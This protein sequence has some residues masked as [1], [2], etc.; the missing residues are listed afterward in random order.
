MF[1]R[2]APLLKLIA[3][4]SLILF[5][6]DAAVFRSGVYASWM[7]PDSTGGSVVGDIAAIRHYTDST[8][9]NVLVLGN[10]QIGEGFSWP[11]A[12]AAIG[13][14]DL[15]FVNGSVAGTTPRLWSYLLREIDPDCS[16]YAAIVMMIDYDL[17]R[18][19]S[20]FADYPLD[21]SYATPL[22]RIGD[23]DDYPS[24]FG[25]PDLRARA[26]RAILLPLQAAHE[27]ILNFI[28]HPLERWEK[29]VKGRPGWIAA[30]AVY[31]GHREALPTLPID[32]DTGMPSAW[33]PDAATLKPKLESYFRD[34]RKYASAEAMSANIDYQRRWV[35]RI[36]QC[37][38]AH[39]VPVIAFNVPRGPWH[40]ALTAAP[41]PNAALL[42]LHKAGTITLLPGDAF[43]QFEQPQFF[44]DTLHM[45]HTGREA[46]SALLAQKVAPLVH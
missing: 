12:D 46:F 16:R 45:N 9:R 39:D 3:A 30:T 2:I 10:S 38:R 18:W 6:I 17:S 1:K 41:Q 28:V 19:R 26:R 27:D 42:D 23:L 22:L 33:G 21:T 35:G 37:Y 25:D 31:P 40:G 13:K 15:H 8:R 4:I 43:V 20:S 24:S 36:A 29:I 14:S 34:L 7:E 11:T 32:K 44:V 5:L